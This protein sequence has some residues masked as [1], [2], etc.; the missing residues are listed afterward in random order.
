MAMFRREPENKPAAP[1]AAPT[2]PAERRTATALIAPGCRVTGT[3][4]GGA[5]VQ[6]DGELEGEIKLQTQ[7]AIGPGGLVR[8]DIAARVVRIGG[9]VVGNVRGSE[10]VEVLPSGQ[11]EGDVA[12]PRVVISEGAF[13]KGKV[14]MTGQAKG[15]GA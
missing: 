11:L 5:D 1:P 9:K 7:V 8:G 12:A 13:F 4:G 3:I 15:E 6:I 14:E 10:R 2:A